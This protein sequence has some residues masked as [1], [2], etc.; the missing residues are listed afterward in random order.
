VY[1]RRTQKRRDAQG[2]PIVKD[3]SPEHWHTLIKE[4]HQG[5]ISWQEYEEN[6]KRLKANSRSRSEAK[7]SAPR[8]GLALLQGL[9]I[10]GICAK[11]MSVRYRKTRGR[12]R[13]EYACKGQGDNL[14]EPRCQ[15]MPGDGIDEAVGALVVKAMNPMALDVVLS[16]QEELNRRADETD[17]IRQKQV[18][19]TRYEVELARRRYMRVD[20]DNRLVADALEA[21]W[22]DKL[23]DLL[24]AEERYKRLREQDRK[25]LDEAMREKIRKLATNFPSLWNDPVTPQRERKRMVH[26]LLEDVTLVKKHADI[27]AHVRFK[28]GATKTLRIPRSLTSWQEWTTDSKVVSEIDRLLDH[29]TNSQVADILNQTGFKSGT[30]KPFHGN[31]ISKIRRAYGLKSR[32]ER[33]REAGM[34]TRKEL[35]DRQGVNQMTITKWRA[36]GRLTAHLA[37]DQGQYLFEDPGNVRLRLKK[38]KDK[39]TPIEDHSLRKV[40]RQAKEVQ[41]E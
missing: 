29:H 3:L 11:R 13:P 39:N 1:G 6:Q 15:S 38:K 5:Y 36:N 19:R 35:A 14:A 22:N 27:T 28:G 37:D 41:Y 2:R 33:L 21:D 9:V 31:R 40:A 23:R 10:C 34:L 26:L 18:E 7:R 25:L 4:A 8:E 12:L 30:G 20:P 32:Y 24:K 16:V 17:R